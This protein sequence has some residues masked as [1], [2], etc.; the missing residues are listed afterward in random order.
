MG[1]IPGRTYGISDDGWMNGE[2][3]TCGSTT[4]SFAMCLPHTHFCCCWMATPHT[5]IQPQ[6]EKLLRREL[7]CLPPH[8]A[9]LLQPLVNWSVAVRARLVSCRRG[10][11]SRGIRRWCTLASSSRGVDSSTASCQHGPPQ[12]PWQPTEQSQ[13]TD[14]YSGLEGPDYLQPT[15]YDGQSAIYNPQSAPYRGIRNT[16]GVSVNCAGVLKAM[17][18][19]PSSIPIIPLRGKHRALLFLS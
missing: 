17:H 12:T 9:H 4:I 14:H 5:V 10:I 19:D 6:C 8:A 16:A 3:L 2:L 1:N 13:Q 7:F 18:I 11:R 15:K